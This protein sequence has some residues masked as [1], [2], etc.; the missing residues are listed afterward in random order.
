MGFGDNTKWLIVTRGLNE[1]GQLGVAMGA[2]VLTFGGL[3]GVGDLAAT[4]A[5]KLSISHQL[6]QRLAKGT[7]SLDKILAAMP[8]AVE[9]V[10]TT[11][12]IHRHADRLG[13][14]L[15]IINAVYGLLHENRSTKE[16]LDDLMSVPIGR[17][18]ASL[19]SA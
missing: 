17:E 1:M 6:G 10:P 8:S 4:C 12:A 19:G 13:L 5:S 15:P 3:A 16:C 18:L 7:E 2:D 9:A 14:K 11:A